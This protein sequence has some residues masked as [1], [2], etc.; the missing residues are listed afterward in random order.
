MAKKLHYLD[1]L[2]ARELRVRG[3][4]AKGEKL[5]TAPGEAHSCAVADQCIFGDW[6]LNGGT[7]CSKCRR[8]VKADFYVPRISP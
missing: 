8:F 7:P 5:E 3:L 4:D 2:R 6:V 1:E